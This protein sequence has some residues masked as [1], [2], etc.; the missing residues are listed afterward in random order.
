MASAILAATGLVIGVGGCGGG[1][2]GPA[3]PTPPAYVAFTGTV[4]NLLTGENVGNGTITIPGKPAFAIRGGS[5]TV[6]PSDELSPGEIVN[7]L[8]SAEGCVDRKT[9]V[10]VDATGLS[11][12][13]G[14]RRVPLDLVCDAQAYDAFSHMRS[15]S[16]LGVER[17]GST[18][19][20]GAFFYDRQLFGNVDG[21][22]TILDR[23]YTVDAATVDGVTAAAGNIA[24]FTGGVLPNGLTLASQTPEANW[25]S[26][27]QVDS[28]WLIYF[29]Y[30][31]ATYGAID[32]GKR[33]DISGRIQSALL[34]IKPGKGARVNIAWDTLEV[35]GGHDAGLWVGEGL[36][37]SR[38]PYPGAGWARPVDSQGAPLPATVTFGKIL[39]NRKYHQTSCE[40]PDCQS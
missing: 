12:N 33:P 26:I 35:L 21:V 4:K 13:I 25:P 11:V 36:G 39:Y 3:T 1:G 17:W 18:Q 10:T 28:G 38:P 31:D 19:F 7:V 16:S 20:R 23:S 40:V 9:P 34:A 8:I 5:F 37:Q 22:L 6:T 30:R 14:D 27:T 15:T 29:V 2:A 32:A 24:A